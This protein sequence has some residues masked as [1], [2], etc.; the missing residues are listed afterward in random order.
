MWRRYI[1][2][3][4][5]GWSRTNTNIQRPTSNKFF[6]CGCCTKMSFTQL[7][8]PLLRAQNKFFFRSLTHCERCPMW[9]SLNQICGWFYSLMVGSRPMFLLDPGHYLLVMP[10]CSLMPR[11]TQPLPALGCCAAP[12]VMRSSAL[13][14]KQRLKPKPNVFSWALQLIKIS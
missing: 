5:K 7:S 6:D 2:W 11:S 3:V 14:Q 4:L 12:D 8:R 9:R 1:Y 10:C 13:K